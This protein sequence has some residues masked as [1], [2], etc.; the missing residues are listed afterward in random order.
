MSCVSVI[1]PVGPE[2]HHADFLEECIG[3]V[4]QQTHRPAEILLI[5]DMADLFRG[6]VKFVDGIAEVDTADDALPPLRCWRAPWHLGVAGVFN[7]GVALAQADLVFMLGADDKLLPN[8]LEK[9]IEAY[10]REGEIDAYYNVGVAHSDGREDQ[11]IACH[12]AMVTKGL[13]RKTGGFPPESVV[14]AADTMFLSIMIANAPAPIILV[15]R[16]EPLYWYRVHENTD[17][18]QRRSW[19]SILHEVR[20]KLTA[21]WRPPTW[22]RYVP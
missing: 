17:T 8:C 20:N 7:C 3:S 12:A 15:D 5:D 4:L 9:C 14:G 2:K 11:Y 19:F 22:R 6:S 1:I 13:W 16:T 21:D 18:A 10:L